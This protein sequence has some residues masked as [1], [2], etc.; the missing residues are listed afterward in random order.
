MLCCFILYDAG[1]ITICVNSYRM[2]GSDHT[3]N[4]KIPFF[5][6]CSNLIFIH[7]MMKFC[8]PPVDKL[9][10][11]LHLRTCNLIFKFYVLG[12]LYQS[13]IL[14]I[15][16]YLNM[17]LPG[18]PTLFHITN[19]S[20]GNVSGT[21]HWRILAKVTKWNAQLICLTEQV[22]KHALNG[23]IQEMSKPSSVRYQSDFRSST[24]SLLVN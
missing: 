15:V 20:L 13:V 1:Y 21:D 3:S 12:V 24:F 14:K 6:S 2:Q 8:D 18:Y 4:S 17:N 5:L 22:H 9:M 10:L 11:I 19:Q 7:F 23:Y 16:L